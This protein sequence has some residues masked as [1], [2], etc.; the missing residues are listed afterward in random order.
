MP[1]GFVIEAVDE[2][3][4][5]SAESGWSGQ[6]GT[7]ADDTDINVNI[8]LFEGRMYRAISFYRIRNAI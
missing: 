1:G 3:M 4:V 2:R 6:P 5:G 8:E 7:P